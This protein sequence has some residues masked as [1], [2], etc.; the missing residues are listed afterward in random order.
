MKQAK[1]A[2]LAAAVALSGC[3][4]AHVDR[5]TSASIHPYP[6]PS[7]VKSLAFTP[8]TE[9]VDTHC[10]PRRLQAA[11]ADMHRK[12][13]RAPVVTSGFRPH[14]GGSQHAH[15]KAADIRIPGVAPSRVAAYARTIPGIGGVGT[16][17]RTGIVHVDVG[18]RRD[19][20]Y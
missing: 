6:M 7:S 19:W 5:A 13:G 16:Y 11:L 3:A 18:P 12:F 17:R 14:S 10:F 2:I 15:C 9:K 20:R 4:S 8:Q 1:T